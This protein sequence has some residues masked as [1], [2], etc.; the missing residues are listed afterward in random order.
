MNITTV[1]QN[2]HRWQIEGEFDLSAAAAVTAVRGDGMTVTK[3]A[4]GTYTVVISGVK[5]LKM[6]EVLNRGVNYFGT[7]P[8]TA[9][10][11]RVH[12]LVQATNGTDDITLVLK[13]T[14]L[15]TSGADTDGTAAVGVAFRL[16]LRKQRMGN[17]FSP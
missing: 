3:S 14:A 5:A 7:A 16:V 10:G 8:A 2:D 1:F 4:T 13:T 17:P 12:S 11:V 6:Y 9:L 15:P